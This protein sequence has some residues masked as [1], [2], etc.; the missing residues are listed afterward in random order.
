ML[1]V[2]PSAQT[3]ILYLQKYEITD[4]VISPGSRNAPLAIGFA[5]N[6]SFNCYSII[7]E[8]SAGFFA[9][10]IAQQKKLPVILLC[11]SG[12][13]ILNYYPAVS[14]A[15]YSEIPLIVLSADRPQYKIGIG[16]GQ[17]INQTKVFEKNIFYSD[18]LIQDVTHQTEEILKSN[19]QS[20]LN[21]DSNSNLILDSQKE[22]QKKN[23]ET[24]K[25]IILN[26][27]NLNKPVHL[28][29]PFEEPLYNFIEN[30]N[31]KIPNIEQI[32]FDIVEEKVNYASLQK[33]SKVL[34]LIG[35]LNPGVLST[36]T[37]KC[38][39]KN[40][41]IVVLTETTSNI[42]HECFFNNIDKLIAPIE[43]LDNKSEVF[44]SLKPDLL[45]TIGGMVVSKK[46]KTFLRNSTNIKH[47]H[48]GTQSANDTYFKNVSQLKIEPNKFFLKF[49]LKESPI[50]N[51]YDVWKK[52]QSKREIAHKKFIKKIQFSDLLAYSFIA[53]KIPKH[54]QIQ[55]ANSSTIRYL[56]LFKMRYNNVMYCNRGTSG[57]DG[58]TSTA[59][60]A[61]VVSSDPV[62]LITG[63]LSFFYD[64]NGLWNNYVS[65]NFRII[66]INNGGGGIFRILPGF[67]NTK[68]F[69]KYIE[70]SQN[71]KAKQI[72]KLHGFS[73]QNRKTKLGLKLALK[74]FFKTSS[75]PKILEISTNSE[76]SSDT[77]KS[78]FK[79]LSKSDSD[80]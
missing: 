72:A 68:L 3:L 58:S 75:K 42:Y 74:S 49:S 51:Y 53:D 33:N 63:D 2:I 61:S 14:E 40:K 45:I 71:L 76:I 21:K 11:T 23:Q 31:I 17:T 20:L 12:S 13:A 18:S 73:Y 65:P 9:I 24:I 22:I 79:F 15:Y 27:L 50:S 77:L 36:K 16:D 70:T 30:P 7:D 69:T 26:C 35:C 57:I 8:R 64:V 25:K 39:A 29:I 52:I 78:Y 59:I 34:V 32:L 47:I 60:G 67:Q 6:K 55:A 19:R 38:L 5:S 43:H 4:V 80:R 10:G 46:I 62:L 66:I 54:T 44:K 56:Q 28:N 1:P 41:K 37:V 48:I